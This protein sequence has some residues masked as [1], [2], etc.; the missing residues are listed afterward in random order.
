VYVAY[1]QGY[2][3]G[4]F[5]LRYVAPVRAVV[6]FDAEKVRTWEAGI[7]SEWFDRR[8]RADVAVFT[9][10]YDKMQLTEY[11]ELGA[12]LTVNAGARGFAAANLNSWQHH[13]MVWSFTTV[14]ES[15]R[16]GT[17]L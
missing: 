10:N 4:G 1:S 17:H 6:P 15:C 5:N 9:T 14:L 2:K 16:R 8:L 7:K 3:G 12:P 13:S 11:Q